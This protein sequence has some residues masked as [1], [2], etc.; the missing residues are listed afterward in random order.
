VKVLDSLSSAASPSKEF[1]TLMRVGMNCLDVN[2][3]FVGG[4][5]T[6]A[7][8]LLEGFASVGNGCRFRVFVTRENYHL[9]ANFRKRDNFEI[10]VIS[11]P[12]FSLRSSIC[13]ATSVSCSSEL[14]R[15]ASGLIFENIRELMDAESDV[16]Y[17]PT[18]V[19][20][21]FNSRK[22]TVLSMHDIQHVHHPEFFSWPRRVSRKITYGLSARYACY[23]QASSHY[24]KED[25]LSHFPWLSPE[26]IEVIPSGALVE[27]F[28]APAATDSL[29]ERYGLPERFLLFPAQL[30]PHKNHVTVLKAL[31][32]IESKCGVKI[33]LVLTGEKFSAAPEIF[34]FIADKSMD[35]VQYLGKV[36]FEDMVALYQSAAFM[37]TA[38]LHESSSL[39]V[40]EAAAAGTPIIGSRIPPIEELGRVLQLNL[41]DPLDADAL[42]RLISDLWKDGKIAL[43][44][45]A[46]NREEIA[47]YSWENTARKYVQLFERI[48]NS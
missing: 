18:P 45:A 34:K 27:K 23:L 9:F 28:S 44:Q 15:L 5:T 43:G 41:F 16:L 2:P 10:I 19:L 8:G 38:T 7:L 33:P 17:T 39:P 37:I 47:S 21:C 24:I 36:P 22:P 29:S 42:A 46:H 11:D 14:H 35:Y 20:R 1:N 48:V 31:K 6:Y 40:L 13:R 25:L 30:W 32:Q 26:Q 12:L 4:V 3:S